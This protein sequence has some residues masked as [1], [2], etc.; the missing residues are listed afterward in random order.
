MNSHHGEHADHLVR[1]AYDANAEV[2]A[3]MFLGE[4]GGDQQSL[5]WLA[6]FAEAAAAH[7]GPVADVGCGPGS[8]VDHLSKLGLKLIGYDVSTGQI[9]QARKAYPTHDFRVGDLTALE[10]PSDSL[11]GIVARHSIIHIS[12]DRLRGVF[13]GWCT[14]LQSGAP[15]FMSFFGSRSTEAHGTPFNHKVVTAFE[16]DPQTIARLLEDV[17]FNNVQV[18]A[19]PI[20]KGGRPFDHTVIFARKR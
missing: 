10:V 12:P 6:V 15:L 8:V 17:G 2:Y 5:N 19:V 9:G 13:E 11:S 1:D 4:L 20:A 16:L 18:E 14:V 7:T 3:S